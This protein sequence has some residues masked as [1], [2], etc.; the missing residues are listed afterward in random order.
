ML[1]RS[2]QIDPKTEIGPP[3]DRA[4]LVTQYATAAIAVVAAIL[5]TIVR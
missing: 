4:M 2:V 1:R 3:N 5:L